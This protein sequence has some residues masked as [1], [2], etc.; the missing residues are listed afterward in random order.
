MKAREEK[1]GPDYFFGSCVPVRRIAKA[2]RDGRIALFTDFDGTL[3]PIRKDPARCVLSEEARALLQ[4]LAGSPLCSLMVL[5][6]RSLPDLRKRVGLNGIYYGGNHGFDI[7]GPDMRYTH[8]G[9][10][11]LK[12]AIQRAG[13]V[14]E[15]SIAGIQGAWVENKE[16]SITLHY[17]NVGEKAIPLVQATFEKVVDDL[18]GKEMMTVIRGKRVLELTPG[19]RWNKG[20]AALWMLK[21]WGGSC[22]PVAVGD[23]RTDE[24]IFQALGRRGVCIRIGKSTT[25]YAQY[26]L[27]SHRETLRLLQ[28]IRRE[29][30][31]AASPS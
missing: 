4:A 17:R 6:G 5:S 29:V 26:Y 2:L 9:A 22:L 3:V 30:E 28:E 25:T 21:L 15:S 27:K 24:T 31:K 23:D 19:I 10:V 13:R 7:T 14:L 8:P 20:A 12:K 18:S 16:F 11:L 1:P